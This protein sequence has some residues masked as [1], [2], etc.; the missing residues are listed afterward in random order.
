LAAKPI[1]Y[2]IAILAG[3][4]L[5]VA[6]AVLRL[7]LGDWG[8]VVAAPLALTV[9]LLLLLEVYRRT[10]S[11]II[12]EGRQSEALA[13]LI[14]TLPLQS[15]L[16]P[17]REWAVSPDFARVL[18]WILSESRPNTVLELG[19]GVSTI[20]AGYVLK[21]AGHGSVVSF[22]HAV[23]Y[24]TGVRNQLVLHGLQ[25]NVK[26]V[27]APLE[28]IELKGHEYDWYSLGAAAEIDQIDVLIVDGPPSVGKWT[29]YPAL[30]V[31]FDKLSDNARIVVDDYR[32]EKES[33]QFWLR[34]FP[35]FDMEEFDTEKG[36]AV[37][38]RVSRGV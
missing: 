31:L 23:S 13:S 16:P 3:V 33:V 36:T 24:L 29:R 18:V 28:Y 2:A 37:L 7:V 21:E 22:E 14:R 4:A 34:E 1:D 15:P 20:V 17:M 6:S 8:W 11:A 30:P 10:K 32:R 5:L 38:R 27:G 12:Q 19:S 9:T 35:V 26:V 25:E